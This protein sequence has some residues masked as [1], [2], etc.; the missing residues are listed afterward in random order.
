MNI[1]SAR[2]EVT[3]NLS[4]NSKVCL[5]QE[6]GLCLTRGSKSLNQTFGNYRS[7]TAHC[8]KV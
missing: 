1:L 3:E 2:F 7:H 6:R 8:E 4:F 5:K